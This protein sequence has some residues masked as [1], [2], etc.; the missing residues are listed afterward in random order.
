M[1]KTILVMS[2]KG[3]VGKTTVSVNLAYSLSV[4]GKRAGLLDADIHGPNVP[5]MLGMEGRKPKVDNGK[6]IPIRYTDNL[7]VMSFGFLSSDKDK[8]IIWRGP[9]KHKA[10]EQIS[11]DVEWG[12]IDYLVVDFPPG[13]GDEHMSVVMLFRDICGAV[14]VSTP[15]KAA[16]A[17][18]KKSLDFCKEMKIPVIGAIENMSGDIFGSGTVEDECGK[19][20]IRFLGRISLSGAVS[21]SG[22][23][24]K[25][26][27]EYDDK[28]SVAEFD[29]AAENIL[30]GV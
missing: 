25:T 27:Y 28:E 15:Q 30:R 11:R 14:I 16:L 4:K 6:I 22:E 19:N 7:S 20:D 3:G 1:A 5:V 21:L 24:G 2:G 12:D 26:L 17:D 23:E 18:M 10:L 29:K 8:A 9:M 13:T